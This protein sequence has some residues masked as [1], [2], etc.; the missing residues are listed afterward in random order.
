MSVFEGVGTAVGAPP[1]VDGASV[2]VPAVPAPSFLRLNRDLSLSI[3]SSGLNMA[4]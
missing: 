1:L 2:L 3:A 4:L